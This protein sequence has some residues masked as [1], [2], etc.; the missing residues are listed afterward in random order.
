MAPGISRSGGP[1]AAATEF[2]QTPTEIQVAGLLF[3]FFPEV[4]RSLVAVRQR[5]R[6]TGM[7]VIPVTGERKH[8]EDYHHKLCDWSGRLL[9]K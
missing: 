1:V 4:R 6:G 3:Q 8:S 9:P 5:R 7:E 2:K